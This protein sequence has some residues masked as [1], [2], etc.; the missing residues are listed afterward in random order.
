MKRLLNVLIFVI[1]LIFLANCGCSKKGPELKGKKDAV[2]STI[3]SPSGRCYEVLTYK[4]YAPNY[5]YGFM[6][7]SQIPCEKMY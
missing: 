7:M 1:L 6:G 4:E 5:G 3:K 2:W